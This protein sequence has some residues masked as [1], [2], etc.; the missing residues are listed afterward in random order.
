MASTS[1]SYAIA[2]R[3]AHALLDS[4]STEKARKDIEKDIAGLAKL[5]EESEDFAGIIANPTLGASE[6]SAAIAAIAKKGKA[7]DATINALKVM[8]DNNRLELLPVFVEA[9]RTQLSKIRGE[10]ALSLTLAKADKKTVSDIQSALE[11]AV[12]KKT[13]LTVIENPEILGGAIVQLGSVQMDYSVAGK[14]GRI[15]QTLKEH[16]AT[17]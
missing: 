2:S 15:S 1:E 11:K 17:A 8:A 7:A 4:V 14:L 9:F 10:V 6:K 5:L 3:Y 12:G 13:Q 16:I